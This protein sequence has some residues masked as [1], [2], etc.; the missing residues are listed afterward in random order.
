MVFYNNYF[1]VQCYIFMIVFVSLLELFLKCILVAVHYKTFPY[2]DKIYL[3]TSHI[4]LS[5]STV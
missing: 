3:N 5:M 1:S 2:S 4:G